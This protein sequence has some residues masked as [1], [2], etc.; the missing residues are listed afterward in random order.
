MILKLSIVGL[1]IVLIVVLTITYYTQLEGFIAP[2]TAAGLL[3]TGSGL[4]FKCQSNVD[5]KGG[6]GNGTIYKTSSNGSG[7]SLIS[8]SDNKNASVLVSD[9]ECLKLG[10]NMPEDV[11]MCT[12]AAASAAAAAAISGAGAGDTST[13]KVDTSVTNTDNQIVRDRINIATEYTDNFFRIFAAMP[14]LNSTQSVKYRL[15]SEDGT[16]L[17]NNLTVTN[18]IRYESASLSLSKIK[19]YFNTTAY[20]VPKGVNSTNDAYASFMIPP[21]KTGTPLPPVEPAVVNPEVTLSETGYDAMKLNKQSNLLNDIQKIV[22]NEMLM[23]RATDVSVKNPSK[24]K[25][26]NRDASNASNRNA[27]NASNRN[28][29]NSSCSQDEMGVLDE[30]GDEIETQDMSKY[31]KKDEIPCWGC[32]LD[33]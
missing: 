22:H 2:K 9:C 24:K 28:A 33:Y 25:R 19:P 3:A 23:H 29:P 1:F 17:T 21:P 15:L 18:D 26:A 10:L 32:S 16:V 20:I 14:S 11:M 4:H 12:G 13:K 6:V 7:G 30:M 27:S 5:I 31:I 8:V